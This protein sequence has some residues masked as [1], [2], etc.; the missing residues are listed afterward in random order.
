MKIFSLFLIFCGF[1]SAQSYDPS[2]SLFTDKRSLDIGQ[3]ITVQVIEFS[4]ASNNAKTETKKDD[5]YTLS[6]AEGTGLLKFLPEFGATA[7]NNMTLKGEGKTSK[8]G[9]LKTK[10]TVKIINKTP[11]GDLVVEGK[12]V[13]EMNGEKEIFVLSG[14]VRPQDITAE[15]T[16]F[17]Y[18]IY[19]AKM[20]YK[21][22]GDVTDAQKKGLF[23]TLLGWIF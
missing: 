21:G 1:I 10:M 19:D 20:V 14:S 15:N 13:I 8:T 5:K 12:R 18:Q 7:G 23:S 4:Q 22:K 17:S 11:S 9:S 3:A 2:F 6:G 16:I